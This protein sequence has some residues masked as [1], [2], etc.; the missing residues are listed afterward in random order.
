MLCLQ[1]KSDDL[2]TD[3]RMLDR[4]NGDYNHDI[5]LMNYQDPQALLFK[6]AQ[7]VKLRASV[8]K[9]CG[10]VMLTTSIADAKKLAKGK[11]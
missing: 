5:K 9:Q 3:V 10:F 1:C 4:G 7:E 2:V 11:T 6:Q 8:C